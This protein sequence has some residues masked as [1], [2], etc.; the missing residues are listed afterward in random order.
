MNF[1]SYEKILLGNAEA[2]R[3]NTEFSIIRS[4]MYPTAVLIFK[5][6]LTTSV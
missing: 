3:M 4:L 1:V 5:I 6:I 2:N